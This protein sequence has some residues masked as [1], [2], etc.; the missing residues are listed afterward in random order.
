MARFLCAPLTKIDFRSIPLRLEVRNEG[1][2]TREAMIR[3][4]KTGRRPRDRSHG[5]MGL[6]WRLR[7]ETKNQ[8]IDIPA[9]D[10]GPAAFLLLPGETYVEYQLYAQSLRPKDFIMVAG[11]GESAPGYIP[12]ERNW[13]EKDANLNWW[14]WV[15]PGSEA[16]LKDAIRRALTGSQRRR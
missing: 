10:F 6:S 12:L 11:Y 5:A 9:I 3:E 14:C 15:A 2:Y 1:A 8:P 4:T 7:A 13:E 16:R